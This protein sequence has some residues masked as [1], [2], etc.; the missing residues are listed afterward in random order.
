VDLQLY[1]RVLW[2]FRGLVTAGILLAISL[3]FFSYVSVDFD[4]G[5]PS[6]AYRQ[7]EQW[8]SLATLGVASRTFDPGSVLTPE[9]RGILERPASE[10]QARERLSE[11]DPADFTTLPRLNEVA[12]QLM[13]LATSDGVMR[14]MVEDGRP[15]DGV[16][17][18]FPVTSGD[19]L[20]PYITFSAVAASPGEA[21]SLAR[22]H[23]DAFTTFVR[24]RQEAAGIPASE[25]VV[26]EV[27]NEAQPAA[28]LEGRK[29]TQPIIVFL[30]VMTVVLG[31][32]FVL[33]NL[34]PRVR[35]VAS[36]DEDERSREQTRRRS[37]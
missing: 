19:S 24:A 21:L 10:G 1:F 9:T 26:I 13:R 35:T 31:L 36:S 23:V 17:Q 3:A 6:F 37:A 27:I 4:G 28:L 32:C 20:V 33:E 18:T 22:R 11:I 14:I 5:K 34:R 29:K 16:L 30:T 15:I 7:G 2:R 8:E 25:R 12:V